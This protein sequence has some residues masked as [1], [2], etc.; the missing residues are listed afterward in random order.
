[1]QF[2]FDDVADVTEAE[3]WLRTTFGSP[4]EG[5][6]WPLSPE[7]QNDPRM[8]R[9]QELWT[10]GDFDAAENEFLDLVADYGTDGIASYRLAIHLR[11]IG[12]YAPSIVATGNILI[13]AGVGTLSAPRYLAR[14]SYP[15]YYR[16]L[17][18]DVAEE[19]GIDPLLLFSLIRHES[20]FDTYA[21][22][23]AGEK[24]LTQVIPST[25]D[26]IADQLNWPNYQHADLF[27]PYAGIAFGAYYLDEQLERFDGNT[28]AA[29]SGYNAGPGRAITWLDLAGTDPERFMATID[30]STVQLYIQ[31]IY[32]YYDVYRELYGASG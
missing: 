25:G 10:M 32:S 11:S 15:A 22:A 30:I 17:V 6:L 23:G 19:R 29:L 20:R 13:S 21:T 3:N 16:D 8:L 9:G 24:G 28:Y 26:Y 31:R 12:C 2:A 7:L 27:R 14:M 18:L 1:L 4:G 5:P